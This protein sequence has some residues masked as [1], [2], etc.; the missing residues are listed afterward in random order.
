MSPKHGAK[1]G[2][3]PAIS[4]WQPYATLVALGVKPLETRHWSAPERVIGRRVGIH[5][6]RRHITRGDWRYLD[7]RVSAHLGG[8]GWRDRLV[9][10]G[11][12]C[13][14]VLAGSYEVVEHRRGQ[15]VIATPSGLRVIT[16][17]GLGDYE[18]G[19]WCWEFC[20][21]RLVEGDHTIGRQGW[22]WWQEGKE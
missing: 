17:D 1:V 18:V 16:D 14:A 11:V 7:S 8:D 12:I 10:G 15:P 20:D 13:T 6:A 4:L 3:L 22:F 19:R 5:A 9:F 21:I 2:R